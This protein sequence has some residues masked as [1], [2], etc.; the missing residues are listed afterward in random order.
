MIFSPPKPSGI[1][2]LKKTLSVWMLFKLWIWLKKYFIFLEERNPVNAEV[3]LNENEWQA[4]FCCIYLF[5][6]FLT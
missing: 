3:V 1:L 5:C 2:K 4:Q 6:K